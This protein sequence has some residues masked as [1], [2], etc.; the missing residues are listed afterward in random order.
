M[1]TKGYLVENRNRQKDANVIKVWPLMSCGDSIIFWYDIGWSWF[2]LTKLRYIFR[3]KLF[4][5][6]QTNFEFK[7]INKVCKTWFQISD[8]CYLKKIHINKMILLHQ[9]SSIQL[10]KWGHTNLAPK[11]FEMVLSQDLDPIG[12]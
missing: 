3:K 7:L 12:A 6:K 11:D 2:K 9:L 10:H 8:F 4:L 5:E 1:L